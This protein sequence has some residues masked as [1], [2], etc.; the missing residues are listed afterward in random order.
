M[1]RNMDERKILDS[2]FDLLPSRGNL[3]PVIKLS[4]IVKVRFVV[5]RRKQTYDN[6]IVGCRLS[7][8]TRG[9]EI[10]ISFII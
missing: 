5:Q 2:A 9:Q 7:P 10:L 4:M 3:L 6:L 8:N 1:L